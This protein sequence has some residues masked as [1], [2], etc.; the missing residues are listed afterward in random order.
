MTLWGEHN[1]LSIMF[2]G[3]LGFPHHAM[4]SPSNNSLLRVYTFVICYITVAVKKLLKI[5]QC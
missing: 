1:E 2:T 4:H 5:Q 3:L